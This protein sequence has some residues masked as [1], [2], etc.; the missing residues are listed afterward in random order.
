MT[1]IRFLSAW[2]LALVASACVARADRLMAAATDVVDVGSADSC[3]DCGADVCSCSESVGGQAFLF[4]QTDGGVNLRGWVAAGF[5][6]NTADPVSRF[7]G[8]YNAVDRSNE[9]MLNQLYLIGERALPE[10]GW[11]LGARVDL[12]YGEDFWLAESIGFERYQ[13]GAEKWNPEYYGL[14]FPQ[15]YVNFGNEDLSFQ[16]G[17]FYSIVGYEGLMAP[18]NFFYSKSYS[19]QFG[20]PFQ[21]WGGQ[22]NYN[23]NSTWSLQLGLV[24]GWNALDR[25]S[26]DLSFIGK[27]KY[28]NDCTGV[29]T[30]FALITGKECNNVAQ[31]RLRNQDYEN[32]TYY[33][34]L[35]GLPLAC[36]MEYVFHHYLGAQQEGTYDRGTAY[37]YGIDQYLYYTINDCWKAGM[38]FEWF[39]DEDGTRVG[40]NRPSNPNNPPYAG[41]FYSLSFGVNWKP[42]ANFTVRPEI[43]ADW[44]DGD[45]HRLP[46]DDGADS[47][48]LLLGL[49]AILQY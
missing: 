10:C 8:P 23:L 13:T 6:G 2:C 39:R 25:E 3:S 32:R 35:V 46:Y 24:N 33:S 48:Q 43:R 21:H 28:A 4:P 14:A 40:L 11:G 29:W 9:P 26:D 38:R 18:S 42:T 19:Y 45:S 31:I 12:L 30:S 34:W 36:R 22:V 15:A 5:V 20:G 27:I 7:N 17:H 49:D 44:Y 1:R 37:W 16:V 41:D 47:S